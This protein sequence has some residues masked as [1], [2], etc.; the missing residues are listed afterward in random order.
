MGQIEVENFNGIYQI[1]YEVFLL[2]NN[3]FDTQ[4]FIQCIYLGE[5]H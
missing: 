4:I 2:K 1:K 3:W 5:K